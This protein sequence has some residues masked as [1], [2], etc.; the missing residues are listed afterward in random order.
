MA[1]KYE[2]IGTYIQQYI[3]EYHEFLSWIGTSVE[4]VGPGTMTISIPYDQK[5]T[6][7]RPDKPE[8]EADI[9]GG[10][11]ATLI[12]T[13]GGMALRTAMDDPSTGG[14]ATI[15]LNVNYLR[16]ATSDLVATATVVRMGSTVGVSE[17]VVES[18]TPEGETKEVAI[19]QG[20]YRVF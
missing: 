5:L 13:V 1:D 12:D 6:N 16:P 17:V 4:D 7:R 18:E 9:Q 11:A 14:V 3:D 8:E 20:A 10:I 19:G 2:L 15:N